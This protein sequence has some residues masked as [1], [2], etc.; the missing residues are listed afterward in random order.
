MTK[1]TS[2]LCPPRS[3]ESERQKSTSDIRKNGPEDGRRKSRRPSTQRSKSKDFPQ[4][5]KPSKSQTRN[6]SPKASNSSKK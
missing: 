3:R 6:S 2:N 4:Q 5:T 1:S